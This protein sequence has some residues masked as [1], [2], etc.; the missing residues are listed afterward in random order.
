MKKKGFTL[1]ELL[2]VIAIIGILIALLLPA[3]Q[4]AREAARRMQCTNNLKQITLGMHGYHD[5]YDVFPKGSV[6]C[7]TPQNSGRGYLG[8]HN[9]RSTILPFMEQGPLYDQL[10]FSSTTGDF[11]SHVI[12]S[13]SGTNK[14]LHNT[15]ISAYHCPSNPIEP[16]SSLEGHV[17]IYPD[18][19]N[20]QGPAML[21]DYVGISGAYPDPAGRTDVVHSSGANGM[22]SDTGMLLMNQASS[23]ATVLDGTSNTMFVGEQSALADYA[24]LRVMASSNYRAGW[25]GTGIA[26][27]P[28]VPSMVTVKNWD[29]QT[30][31][32]NA[33]AV[34]ITTVGFV[35]NAS[36]LSNSTCKNFCTYSANTNIASSHSGGAN[37]G[38]GDGSVRFMTSTMDFALLRSLASGND[39]I[40][41]TL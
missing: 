11:Q 24:G 7:S 18:H 20:N 1:V 27:G 31:I 8:I 30:G 16:L 38:F 23:V 17:Q 5:V 21:I 12:G 3:V 32:Q 4:A 35:I 36:P 25:Y 34:G 19:I 10:D 29:E 6:A 39:G 37:V 15:V 14:A 33:Y 2:V 40:S 9:W 22:F 13:A 28:L 41:Q 26:G